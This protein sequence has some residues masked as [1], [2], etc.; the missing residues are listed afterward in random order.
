M[1]DK[2]KIIKRI[3]VDKPSWKKIFVESNLPEALLPLKKISQNLWWSWNVDAQELFCSIDPKK[4][5]ET[6][7]NPILLL[8]RV[9]YQ[10]LLELEEDKKFLMLMNQVSN[11]L[12]YYLKE[13]EIRESPSIAYFSMEYGIHDSLKIYS[14]GLGILAGDYLKEA[15]DAKVNMIGVG[16]LYRYGYFKQTLSSAGEQI[17]TYEAEEFANIPVSAVPDANGKWLT[18]ELNFPGRQLYARVWKVNVGAVNL[19]LLDTDFEENQDQDRTITHHLYGGDNENR[20]KQEILLGF[21]GIKVLKALGLDFDIYHCNEGHAAF[22]GLERILNLIREQGLTF[23]EAK[24]IIRASTLFTTHTPVPAGHDAFPDELLKFYLD[25]IP[26]EM[27]IN[28]D[29]FVM[30]GKAFPLETHFNMSYLA[31][32]LS[33]GINGVSMLHG[34]VSKE[35]FSDLY[36]G[37][38]PKELSLGYVTNGVHYK[39]WVAKEWGELHQKYFGKEFPENQS[40]LSLWQK[41]STVPSEEIWSVKHILKVKLIEYI[42]ERFTDA[43]IQRHEDPKVISEVMN[44]LNPNALTVG[45]ARRF[46]TYKRAHLLFRDLDRLAQLLGNTDRPVQFIFAGKAHPADKA[47]QDLIKYIIDISRRPEFLGKIVFIP[48]YDIDLAKMLLQGVDVWLNTPTRPLEASGTS[49][50]KGVMNGTLHFSVLDGWWVEGYH[51]DAGWALP[52]ENSYDVAEFQDQL[53]AETIYNIFEDEIIPAYYDRNEKGISVRWVGY[54]KN[55]FSQ[56]APHFTT[57]RML[58]DYKQKFYLPQSRRASR[59]IS[60]HYE[61]ARN[62]A[63]WKANV[64]LK[65]EGITVKEIDLSERIAHTYRIGESYPARVV[66]N[67]NGLN[68]EDIG[69][70]LVTCIPDKNGEM[71][72]ISSQSFEIVKTENGNTTYCHNLMLNDP[73]YFNYAIRIFAWNKELPHRQDFRYVRWI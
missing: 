8:E 27:D 19:Y 59:L 73:G 41:I 47:G 60:N 52:Q 56:V 43:W 68:P 26:I 71:K 6:G 20:L 10:R 3:I 62:L 28:W 22:I 45:F 61:L 57:V 44:T 42:K 32:Q 70:E 31:A 16:L 33:Q 40:D 7:H 36:G 23:A 18:I 15:S 29:Q 30:L 14:G 63:T 34:E 21:G 1:T 35:L 5:K 46:A 53:D 64:A 72:F 25:R 51:K 37:Y 58:Q 17:A 49:G 24:E 48:N 38:F 69:V 65:W 50:E 66:L 4:W 12:I 13:R 2:V 67:L 54:I 11:E 9:G 39:T 55:T